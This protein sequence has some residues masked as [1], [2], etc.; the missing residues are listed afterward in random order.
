MNKNAQILIGVGVLSVGAYLYWKSTQQSNYI[1]KMNANGVKPVPKN[2]F[3]VQSSPNAQG[4]FHN[5]SGNNT[6]TPIIKQNTVFQPTTNKPVFAHADGVFAN[7]SGD[8]T[9]LNP[10]GVFKKTPKSKV[11]AN[12]A[13]GFEATPPS[14]VFHNMVGTMDTHNSGNSFM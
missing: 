8:K 3:K 2:F 12:A 4:N 5:A 1:G 10:N 7:A 11:F 6:P 14:K 13:G 9:L